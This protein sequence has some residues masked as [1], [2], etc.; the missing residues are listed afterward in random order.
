VGFR[1]PEIH[2]ALGKTLE[3]HRCDSGDKRK[4]EAERASVREW[5]GEWVNRLQLIAV[6][7]MTNANKKPSEQLSVRECVGEWVNRMQLIAVTVM[8]K[9]NKK[10]SEQA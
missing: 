9:A 10:P 4:Q 7:V 1:N 5:V 3:T 8:A 2:E 6:I